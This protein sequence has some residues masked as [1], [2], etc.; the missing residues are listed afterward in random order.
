MK[1]PKWVKFSLMLFAALIL[2]PQQ[3]WAC[4]CCAADGQYRIGMNKPG[5]SEIELMKRIRFG[6]TANVFTGEAE[7]EDAVKGLTHPAETYSLTGSLKAK[8]WKLAFRDGNNLGTLNLM[9][10][11]KYLSFRADIHDGQM[12]GGGG[13]LL[14]KE[15]RFQGIV[16]GSGVFSAGLTA[17]AKYFLV[18][19]G[20]GNNCDNAEDFTHWR[21]EITGRKAGYAFYGAFAKPTP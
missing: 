1:C 17:P 21:L 8:T 2:T 4:A 6:D 5:N 20:R 18:F 13:P 12:G 11:A 16:N 3:V 19:Q 9:L 7:V 15:W 14:Y 10:P